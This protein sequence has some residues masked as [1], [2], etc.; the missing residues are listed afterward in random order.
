[1]AT[2]T[3]DKP[4][5]EETYTE[6]VAASNL[7]FDERDGSPT[8]AAGMLVAAGWSKSRLGAQLMRLHS[9]WDGASKPE[10]PTPARI[11]LLA[12]TV[13]DAEIN[14]KKVPGFVVVDGKP[15]GR[16]IWAFQEANR[17]YEQELR[18]LVGKLKSLTDAR[19][20]VTLQAMKWKIA[21]PE[22]TAGA[23]IKY[24]LESEPVAFC[25]PTESSP[26]SIH[27]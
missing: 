5:I 16:D 25:N 7:K 4:N 18:F 11:K 17:W 19:R 10:K 20:E 13:P 12:M 24:C 9:E 6:A 14:G 27:H 23:V 22:R 8:G 21:D 1:M 3:T 15:V 2:D 26:E